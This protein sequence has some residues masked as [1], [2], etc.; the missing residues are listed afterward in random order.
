M[1]EAGHGVCYIL[2]C[3]QFITAVNGTVFQLLFPWL[4]GYICKRNRN[5]LGYFIGL[6]FLGFSMQY[7]ASYIAS[8][9][10]GLHV[11]ADK[12]FLG[13]DGYHDFDYILS[14]L[15]LVNADWI[16]G[17]VVKIAGYLL[18]FYACYKMIIFAWLDNIK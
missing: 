13:I 4:L 6:F 2:H 17:W 5:I 12:S 18:M 16:I 10:E 9:H 1:Y 14:T 7:T 8:A 15:Y 11:S 3:S